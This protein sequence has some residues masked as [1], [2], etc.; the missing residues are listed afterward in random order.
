MHYYKQVEPVFDMVKVAPCLP[1]RKIVIKPFCP[2]LDV[3]HS[4][5]YQAFLVWGMNAMRQF[6][7]FACLRIPCAT[8]R[9]NRTFSMNLNQAR[10]EFFCNKHVPFLGDGQCENPP[11]FWLDGNPEPDKFR[12]CL[13]KGLIHNIFWNISFPWCHFSSRFVF[14]NPFPHCNMASLDDVQERQCPNNVSQWQA[15]KVQVQTMTNMFQGCSVSFIAH[16]GNRAYSSYRISVKLTGQIKVLITS[17]CA[18]AIW[19]FCL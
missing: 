4:P 11:V 2:V 1:A 7:V 12:T 15:K 18:I 14:L 9:G 3:L 8:I 5:L 19:A 6:Q 16:A 13:D 17:Q 10:E